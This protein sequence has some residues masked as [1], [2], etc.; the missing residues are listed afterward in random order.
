MSA[1]RLRHV[2]DTRPGS[3]A[4]AA[5]TAL[6]ELVAVREIVHAFLTADR[7]EEVFQYALERVSPLVGASFASIYLV[8]EN[9]D[10]M[11]LVAACNWPERFRPFLGHMR[12]RLGLGP[13]GEAASERRIIQVPDVFADDSV[14]DWREVAS[15]IGFRALVAIPLQTHGRVLGTVTFY[16]AEPGVAN[17]E[18]SGLLKIV[19]DQLAATAEKSRLIDDLRRANAALVD[20]NE[21]LE[22]QYAAALEARR[23]KDEFLSNMSHELRTPLTAVLGYTYL[24][25]EGMSGPLTEEQR[26]TLTQ[27]TTSSERL[28]VLI[29]D[30]LELTSLKR[31]ELRVSVEAFDP[32]EAMRE[33]I[34]ITR[35]RMAAVA[36]RV[37]F[38]EGEVRWIRSDRRKVVKIL[39]NLL[40]NAYKFTAQ[41][42]VCTTVEGRND[43]V[44]FGVTDTGIGIAPEVQQV[45]FDEFRQADGSS[46]RPYGGSGL[47]LALSRQ[48]AR[49]LGGDIQLRSSSSEGSSFVLELPL[50]YNPDL[51]LEP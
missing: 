34:T 26:H 7:P 16:F 22:R 46:T 35:G 32:R 2:I 43:V 39:S 33:A 40:S 27:V 3:P 11:R 41:G 42:E 36:L 10:A 18:E 13:S 21:E 12:V 1:R 31:G 14:A 6:R 17:A 23:L 51:R 29:E 20:S 8:D 37:E 5:D 9:D 24:L 15:E 4:L 48:L 45:V 38:P 25:Q 44:R 49:L 30:L 19:A 50:E 28:L 47:G